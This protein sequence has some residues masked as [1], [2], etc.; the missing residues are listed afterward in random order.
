LVLSGARVGA[1]AAEINGDLLARGIPGIE[2][3]LYVML[4]ARYGVQ[5]QKATW[6]RTADKSPDPV[7]KGLLAC[8]V[9]TARITPYSRVQ[10][11]EIVLD[12]IAKDVPLDL[13][14]KVLAD[15][16]IGSISPESY[17]KLGEERGE[18]IKTARKRRRLAALVKNP[19]EEILVL[20]DET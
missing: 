1:S 13:V 12:G 14:N 16:G 11:R 7:L 19:P 17:S 2:K 3:K 9:P 5:A 8:T 15:H 6:R 10:R 20:V 18:F 4:V